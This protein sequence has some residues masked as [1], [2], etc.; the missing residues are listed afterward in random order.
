MLISLIRNETLKLIRRKRFAVVM[1]ILFAIVSIVT[2]SQHRLL[3]QQQRREWRVQLQ[4][5]VANMQNQLRRVGRTDSSWAR[6]LRAEVSRLQFYLDHDID[7]ERPTAPLFVRRFVNVA[8]FLLLPLLVGILGSDIV[9]A[10]NAEG[11]D[12]LLLTRPVRRW[13]ILTSKL[14]TLWMFATLT[15][16][17]GGLMAFVIP[18]A[19]LPARGW[20][21]PT[22]TGF[23]LS[24]TGFNAEAV[25]Q[26]PL[27]KDTLIA[28]GLE[29]FALLCVAA[30]ALLLSVLFKSS[31]AA[32]GTMLASLI[33][34]TILTRISPDWT[35]GKYLFVSAL[36][37][38]DY[39]SG[40]PPP[41]DGM[42]MMFCIALLGLWAAG[43]LAVSYAI[44]I[45]RD[46]FG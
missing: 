40:E 28:F 38:A 34:G 45:R 33:G 18:A 24:D 30:I 42:S 21:A 6:S 10:E 13:K 32:I 17:C 14:V 37:L 9:S 35:A 7:P 43:A 19:L 23:Q 1:G 2:Y 31:A 39:Y 41:Y 4:Q 36:P 26:L 12:K 25:R 3:Q 11:T 22:F 20:Q 15:L 29:W 5:R 44:F 16:A 8:G 27:W 46:V